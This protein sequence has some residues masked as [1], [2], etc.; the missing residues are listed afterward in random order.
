MTLNIIYLQTLV[1]ARLSGNE[2]SL[3]VLNGLGYIGCR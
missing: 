2:K 1:T 3:G